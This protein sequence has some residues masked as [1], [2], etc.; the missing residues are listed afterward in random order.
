M[1]RS[2]PQGSSYGTP[3]PGSK[4]EKR[5]LAAHDRLSGEIVQLCQIIQSEGVRDNVDD[6]VVTITFGELFRLYTVISNKLVGVLLRAR[7]HG[8]VEFPGE[9][10]FQEGNQFHPAAKLTFTSRTSFACT[11][12]YVH[13]YACLAQN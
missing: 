7:K 1:P 9:T 2:Q 4:S 8:L 5:A 13:V 3:V 11:Q 6:D 10:L 12:E